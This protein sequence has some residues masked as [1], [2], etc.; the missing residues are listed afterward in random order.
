M[1]NFEFVTKNYL[2]TT[3]QVTLVSD[4][5][6]STVIN[7]FDRFS[8]KVY[9]TAG[10]TT[11]T[12]ATLRINFAATLSIERIAL[13]NH[14]LK[15]F[16]VYYDGTTANVIT[17]ETGRDTS[18]SS[19]ATNSATEHYLKFTAVNC[20]SISIQMDLAQTVDTNKKIGELWIG[21]LQLRL[22]FNPD[23][24]GY[25]PIIYS[26]Q[27]RHE[28]SDGGISI[29][30]IREKWRCKLKLRYRNDSITTSLRE[31]YDAKDDFCAVP[32]PT[33]TTWNGDIFNVMWVGPW[34]GLRPSGNNYRDIGFDHEF[35]L[36]EVSN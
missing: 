20:T 34:D 35:S 18:T 14:N 19:W 7:L 28:M 1:A 5:N 11:S 32:F 30:D 4:S 31:L 17:L 9:S 16:R 27:I 33:G 24:T 2:D 8:T 15:Q 23:V 6:T 12:S 3:T 25:D 10:H 13:Q 26:K 22:D 21:A 29:Y 36:E